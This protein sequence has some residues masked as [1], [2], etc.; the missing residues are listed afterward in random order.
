MRYSTIPSLLFSKNRQKLS[1][2][3]PIYSLI[4]VVSNDE[5]P[6]TA[7]QFFPFRQNSNM[8]YLSGIEQPR[9]I[10]C[11]CPDFPDFHFHEVLY[12][13]KPT[14]QQQTWLGNKLTIEKASQLSGIKNVVWLENFE[15]DLEGFMSHARHVYLSFHE[16]AR[17]FD[18]V[19]LRDA[20]YTE[21]IKNLYPLHHYER[22]N[23]V[24][25]ELREIK[26]EEELDLIQTAI[27]ITSKAFNKIIA[28]IQ[29]GIPE[30]EIEAELISEFLKNKSS[31]HA[32]IP[33]VA[34]GVNACILHYSDNNTICNSGNLVLVDFGAEYA[35]YNADITRVFPVNGTFNKRQ[36]EIYLS[37]LKL[38][39]QAIK[40]MKP[41]T[42]LEKINQDMVSY[43]E[44]EMLTLGLLTENRIKNQNPEKP[45]YKEFF[46]HG[47]GHF[48]GID[49]HDVGRKADIL[50]PGMVITCE[51]GLYIQNEGIGI[52][53]ENDILIT[54]KGCENL[55][56]NIPIHPDDI[57]DLMKK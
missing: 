56:K 31:G 51:P 49:V 52:R 8:F 54:K 21:K 48:L 50:M 16:N 14:E 42:S 33:I 9:T 15:K 32:F 34:A 6:R 17:S 18:E 4:I 41:G 39:D 40:F 20:R 26:E 43:F 53:L 46:M 38:H 28:C 10:L 5:M 2:R 24:L 55:S 37:V 27:E 36:R 47:I 7:D 22:L 3:L 57:E 1:R 29:P 45:A 23:P 35:N 11:L 44:A 30:Y 13:E 19:P 12:I 25:S